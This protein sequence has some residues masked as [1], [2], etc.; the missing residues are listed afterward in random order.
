MAAA[1][2][3]VGAGADAARRRRRRRR[4]RAAARWAFWVGLA[5][6]LAAS[7]ALEWTRLYRWEALLPGHAGGVLGYALGPLSMQLARLRR[8]GRAVDR[9][10]GAG[11]GA[12]AALLVAARWPTRIGAL[13]RRAARAPRASSASAPRTCRLGERPPREREQVVEAERA[14][15]DGAPCR[16]SSSRRWSRCRKSSAW[17]R[18][19]RSRCS[20]NWPTPSCRRSTCSTPRRPAQESVTPE[21]LEMTCAADREEAQGLRR[22]GARWS[23]PRRAR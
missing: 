13:A 15:I 7:C 19:A 17:P 22:R 12:G 9:R 21:T 16:S 14:R 5:L 4:P 23:R 11:H 3:A 6:L 8:L 20:P 1:R 18:S 2:L 10:A